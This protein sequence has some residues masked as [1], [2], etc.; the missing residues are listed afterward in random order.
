[1]T[2][3][4][5]IDSVRALADRAPKW[6]RERASAEL[7]I[8]GF[9]QAQL[10]T[11]VLDVSDLDDTAA[12]R[13]AVVFFLVVAAAAEAQVARILCDRS[14][15]P[16]LTSAAATLAGHAIERIDDENAALMRY[17][18]VFLRPPTVI[19]EEAGLELV[20]ALEEATKV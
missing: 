2:P 8:G 3:T 16:A 19:T 6:M 12:A 4:S 13:K 20:E 10:A 15:A 17:F 5:W 11:P 18:D 14:S 9:T 1:M 7:H